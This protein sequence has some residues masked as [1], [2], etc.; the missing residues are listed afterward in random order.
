MGRATKTLVACLAVAVA[1]TG[2]FLAGK[3]SENKEK[4]QK[5]YSVLIDRT[6][7]E[8][9][10]TK[11]A[12]TLVTPKSVR[13]S[14]EAFFLEGEELKSSDISLR[15]KTVVELSQLE[16]SNKENAESRNISKIGEMNYT[17][18]LRE[19][20]SKEENLTLKVVEFGSTEAREKDMENGGIVVSYPLFIKDNI[21]A[22][23][24]PTIAESENL[25]SMQKKLYETFLKDYVKK[26]GAEVTF[27]EDR[28]EQAR[29]EREVLGSSVQELEAVS[30]PN[31]DSNSYSF[32]KATEEENAKHEVSKTVNKIKDK[33]TDAFAGIGDINNYL[34]N[35]S[36]SRYLKPRSDFIEATNYPNPYTRSLETADEEEKKALLA[37][38]MLAIGEGEYNLIISG[39][40]QKLDFGFIELESESA[41]EDYIKKNLPQNTYFTKGKI[42]AY[43]QPDVQGIEESNY[44]EGFSLKERLAY[45]DLIRKYAKRTGLNV[46]YSRNKIENEELSEAVDTLLKENSFE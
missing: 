46:V 31:A 3:Y 23:V 45:Y 11:Q 26:T 19:E 24:E 27:S 2:A 20:D 17:I 6:G 14:L 38:N 42:L 16:G 5:A 43:I 39:S 18:P 44:H 34:I 37:V 10:T 40:R 29:L 1:A 9:N 28:Q 33:V 32:D 21:V 41:K 22:E 30:G 35:E 7:Y 25:P 8:E 12:K 13:R 36:D 15:D 4:M